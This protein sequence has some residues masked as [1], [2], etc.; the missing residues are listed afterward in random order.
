MARA[1]NMRTFQSA[2]RYMF[3]NRYG[4]SNAF[5]ETDHDYDNNKE[6][7]WSD[8]ADTQSLYGLKFDADNV[9]NVDRGCQMG[10]RGVQSFYINANASLGTQ[11]LFIADRAMVITGIEYKH[12]TAGN[13]AGAVSCQV[14]HD[15]GTN[16]PGAGTS[17]MT[18][19]FNCKGAT[20]TVQTATLIAPTGPG[21]PSSTITLNA[22]DRLSVVFTGTL[23]TLAGVVITVFTAPGFKEEVAQYA[24]NANA[25]IATQGF[26]LANRD[27]LVTG[28]SMVWSAAATDAGAVTVDVTQETGTTAPGLGTSILN[29]AVSAKTTAN[30]VNNPSLSG[31]AA[32]LKLS[33]GSRL[34]VKLTGTLTSLAGLVVNVYLQSYSLTSI[35]PGYYGQVDVN[36]NLLANG[37]Q[38]TQSFFIADR[39]YE[40]VDASAIWSVAGTDGGTVTYDIQIDKGT[41]APGSGTSISTGAVSVKTTANTTSVLPLST[42]RRNR[43]LSQGDR[44]SLVMAG[45]LTSLA[46]FDATVSLLPR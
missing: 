10:P 3:A 21:F 32:N 36:F 18:N 4:F 19:S 14:F 45:T 44:L 9:I 15:S 8:A 23:T 46:G 5:T 1:T 35:G 33:A 22:G 2:I 42:S 7:S 24:F 34:S 27:M 20:N 37:S 26:F 39:D 31:T 30:T 16:A 13:D 38:G 25:G 29:A 28:V 43:L 17:V 40:V 41:T 6:L 12:T 11:S